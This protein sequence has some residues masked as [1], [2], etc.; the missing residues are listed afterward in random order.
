MNSQTAF[1]I[2]SFF[3]FAAF[4]GS[5]IFLIIYLRK[6]N[7]EMRELNKKTISLFQNEAM[8]SNELNKYKN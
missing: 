2:L 6:H 3:I 5:L 7:K 4:I 8:D 1:Y